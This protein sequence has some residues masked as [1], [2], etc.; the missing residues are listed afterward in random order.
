MLKELNLIWMTCWLVRWK[1]N[2]IVE[3]IYSAHDNDWYNCI[4]IIWVDSKTIF[5]FRNKIHKSSPSFPRRFELRHSSII[6]VNG[7][8]SLFGM[9]C[10]D[11]GLIPIVMFS[12]IIIIIIII[13]PI[14]HWC[15]WRQI[16]VFFSILSF[17][18]LIGKSWRRALVSNSLGSPLGTQIQLP[19]QLI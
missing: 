6:S 1:I 17:G 7:T 11:I 18:V 5:I 9:S 12:I 16:S 19:F 3:Y 8:T 15:S 10:H 13:N 2:S 4:W 14:W